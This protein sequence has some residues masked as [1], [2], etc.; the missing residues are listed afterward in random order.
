M[1]FVHIHYNKY[2]KLC[3]IFFLLAFFFIIKSCSPKVFLLSRLLK[4]HIILSAEALLGNFRITHEC[5]NIPPLCSISSHTQSCAPCRRSAFL[6]RR[7]VMTNARPYIHPVYG[8]PRRKTYRKYNALYRTA[9]ECSHIHA[10]S[11]PSS[12]AA[13]RETES[14]PPT[15]SP[16]P[17]YLRAT[18]KRFLRR[19]DQYPP[20]FR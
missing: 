7:S 3:A 13:D 8:M 2:F 9:K 5:L 15:R 18:V 12:A 19:A 4:G 20:P 10:S 14:P 17:T 16:F 6:Q 1:V 11:A